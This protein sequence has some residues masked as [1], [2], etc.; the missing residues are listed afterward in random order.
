MSPKACREDTEEREEE[1]EEGD[2]ENEDGEEEGEGQQSD[3]P[4]KWCLADLR[5]YFK[6]HGWDFD[7]TLARI[8]DLAVK[9]MIS[10]EPEIVQ[11][12][13][14]GTGPENLNAQTC[15]EVFGFD[16]LLDQ[17]LKP[18]LL[19]VNVSPSLSSSSPLDRRI[20]TMLCADVLTLVGM[21]PFS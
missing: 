10:V 14:R 7:A 16:V 15:F 1:E 18:W 12:L 21:R 13:H 17:D 2:R 11:V 4:S 6:E 3:V 8:Q 9:T 19:E 20:K 5:Q